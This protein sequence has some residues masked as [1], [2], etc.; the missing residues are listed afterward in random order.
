MSDQD[1][2]LLQ[3]A[4]YLLQ[5]N[6]PQEA[7]KELRRVINE[8]PDFGHAYAMLAMCLADRADAKPEMPLQLVARAIALD[9]EN[10]FAHYTLAFIR[11][12]RKEYD[13]ADAAIRKSIELDP[14]D[15]DYLGFRGAIFIARNRLEEAKEAFLEALE[16][17]PD[18]HQSLTALA[19]IESQ[20]GNV[21]EARRIAQ[22]AVQNSPEDAD[23][24]IARGYSF[25]YSN[26]PRE[27]FEAF[28]EALR[29]D[30]NDESARDGLIRALQMHHFFYRGMFQVF[31]WMARLSGSMQW[32][33]IIGLLIAYNVLRGVLK[34]Y[35]EWTPILLPLII[36]YLLFVFMSWLSAPITYFLLLFNRWGRLALRGRQK[37]SGIV[38]AT[39]LPLGMLGVLAGTRSNFIF[40][41]SLGLLLTMIPLTCTLRMEDTT[42]RRILGVYTLAIAGCLLA[43]YLANMAMLIGVAV[44]MLFVFQF[45]ANHLIIRS[46]A[47]R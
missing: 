11:Y 31:A 1:F 8:H 41:L 33:L 30:P 29:L 45:L 18:H 14:Y 36:L 6:R 34:Q 16:M 13:R 15:A 39:F 3:R 38:F 20:L 26:R 2:S 25:V 4:Y 7:E 12:R 19:Q 37:L 10:A 23:A 42:T 5:T 9:P 40:V 43:A 46:N 27:A 21:G 35:P 24:H 17:D 22:H 44:L 32:G 47:P 28:R